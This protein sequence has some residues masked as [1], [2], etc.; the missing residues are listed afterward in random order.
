MNSGPQDLSKLPDPN[1]NLSQKGLKE[2]KE[3]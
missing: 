2:P 1:E 3:R